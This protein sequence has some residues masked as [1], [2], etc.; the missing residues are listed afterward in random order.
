MAEGGSTELEKPQR[1]SG[2]VAETWG[3]PKPTLSNWS[4]DFIIDK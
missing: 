4:L 1:A 2:A 3:S